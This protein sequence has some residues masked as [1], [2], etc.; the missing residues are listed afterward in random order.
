MKPKRTL[1]LTAAEL[2]TVLLLTAAAFIW[3]QRTALAERGYDARGGEYLLLLF[4]VLYYTG[5][6]T[7]LDWIAEL[8]ELKKGRY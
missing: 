6:R 5:K 1:A 3:G 4:P 2:I 7:L 8:R